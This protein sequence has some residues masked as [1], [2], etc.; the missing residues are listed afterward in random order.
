VAKITL[1]P[2][3]VS[4][5]LGK[6]RGRRGAAAGGSIRRP[7]V[8][9]VHSV[10]HPAHVVCWLLLARSRPGDE[11]ELTAMIAPEHAGKNPDAVT[12]ET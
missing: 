9:E 8:A 3:S 2:T 12:C 1:A 6:R 10:H 7:H 4:R 11:I 5:Q